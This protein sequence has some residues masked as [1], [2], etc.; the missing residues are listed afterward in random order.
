MFLQSTLP[1]VHL[2]CKKTLAYKHSLT[3]LINIRVW[4]QDKGAIF[5]HTPWR[6]TKTKSIFF[7]TMAP[8]GLC[9]LD[10]AKFKL[11]V[12]QD[13]DI[14]QLGFWQLASAFEAPQLV[15][16]YTLLIRTFIMVLQLECLKFECLEWGL[17][18]KKLLKYMQN[19]INI[20]LRIILLY[21]LGKLQVFFHWTHCF[22]MPWRWFKKQLWL[23]IWK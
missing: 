20:F 4:T 17:Q 10:K 11:Q 14:L 16:H 7:N 5:S 22:Q 19:C 6:Q 9:M 12:L 1:W 3:N 23:M 18:K 13:K 2:L 8:K 15:K 21:F